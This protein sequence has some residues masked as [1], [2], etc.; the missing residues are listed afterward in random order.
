MPFEFD[1]A[2]QAT[3]LGEGRY[4]TPIIDGWDINGNANG[5]YLMAIAANALRKE[6]ERSHPVSITMHYLSPGP[7]G[8]AE[9]RCEVVKAGR[10]LA[11][12]TGS[13]SR[14]GREIARAIGTFGEVDAA[15]GPHS[16]TSAP[17]QMPAFEDCPSRP[18]GGQQVGLSSRLDMRL[19]PD[20]VGFATDEPNG[21]ALVRGY[22]VFKDNRP[23]DTIGLLLA[24]DAFPPVIFNLFGMKG[25]VP[26]IEMTVHVRAVPV[27]GPIACVFTSRISQGGYWEEDGELWDASGTCVAMSRQLA[28]APLAAD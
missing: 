24:A 1:T 26:T 12:V 5:G 4:N 6:C 10:R 13:I 20:D 9:T 22:F 7:A 3:A 19:H 27:P 18:S 16:V 14:D 15:L 23:V 8:P 21:V 11:T 28:L 17:P 2:I 25:W